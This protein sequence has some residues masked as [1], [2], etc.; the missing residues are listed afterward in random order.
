MSSLLLVAMSVSS[1]FSN[2]TMETV[3][4]AGMDDDFLDDV[5]VDARE[6]READEAVGSGLGVGG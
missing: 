5:D 1:A 6:L 4:R 2:F 3:S